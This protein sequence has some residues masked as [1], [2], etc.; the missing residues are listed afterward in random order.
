MDLVSQ[1]DWD[2]FNGAMKDIE[3]TFFDT[4]I[5]LTILDKN[6]IKPQ[7]FNEGDK[8]DRLANVAY[9]FNALVVYKK[10]DDDS[11][12]DR[13]AEGA[14]DQTE[15]Y[16]LLNYETLRAAG[17]INAD[18]YPTFDGTDDIL[19]VN[20]IEFRIIGVNPLGPQNGT[21]TKLKIQFRKHTEEN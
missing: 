16:I 13:K 17:L 3:D 6:T 20:G 21:F 2:A 5:V 10:L 15:G 7:L 9:N 18:E 4:P 14:M 19:Q 1:A 12:F 11:E 8:L